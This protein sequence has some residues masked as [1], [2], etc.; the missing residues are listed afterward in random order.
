MCGAFFRRAVACGLLATVL[1]GCGGS[2]G[3]PGPTTDPNQQLAKDQ[4]KERLDSIAKSG[5][6]GSALAG[7][8]A[9]IEQ[10]GDKSLLADYDRLEK[11]KSPAEAKKIAAEMSAK[12]K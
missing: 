12:I 3:T 6:A 4:L 1:T 10:T 8:K 11:A 2:G 9:S 7:M 5:Q